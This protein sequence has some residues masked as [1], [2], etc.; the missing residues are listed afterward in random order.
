MKKIILLIFILLN[1]KTIC[2]ENKETLFYNRKE[3]V[4]QLLKK[5][6]T[7]TTNKAFGFDS[8]CDFDYYRLNYNANDENYVDITEYLKD[9]SLRI[10]FQPN[11]DDGIFEKGIIFNSDG[12]SMLRYKDPDRLSYYI[13]IIMP[14]SSLIIRCEG[15][16]IETVKRNALEIYNMISKIKCEIKGYNYKET[17]LEEINGL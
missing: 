9:I 13:E 6:Y 10:I 11:E 2:V 15:K 8:N 16:N 17:T 12:D 14:L 5:R 7:I 1:L 3:I 4:N